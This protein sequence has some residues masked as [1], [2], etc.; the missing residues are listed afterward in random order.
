MFSDCAIILCTKNGEKFLQEQLDSLEAQTHGFDLYIND[1]GSND[2]TYKI[3]K[4]FQKR[5]KY[6][7]H[8]TRNIYNSAPMNFLKTLK[9]IERRYDLY[10]F[11]D[12]DDIWEK[13]KIEISK[14]ELASLD[15]KIPSLF[16]TSTLIINQMSDV[17]DSSKIFK[18]EPCFSNALVQSIAGG[19]T[20][21]FNHQT[22]D[23][24][25]KIINLD[26][27]VSHDWMAYIIVSALGGKVIYSSDSLVKYRK[28]KK[29]L[30][31][32]NKSIK[33]MFS[34]IYKLFQGQ[35]R[36]WT[37]KNLLIL[38]EFKL[39]NKSQEILNQFENKAHNGNFFER[40]N[41]IVNSNVFRQTYL[42]NVALHF[43]IFL[44]KI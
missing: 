41:F 42:S 39:P 27:V 29:N 10:F 18:K 32:P 21:C 16:C 14:M 37:K 43:A 22:R 1:D 19:N 31:G 36:E 9:K 23:L 25:D 33:E 5:S 12:Q 7:I 44:K 40:V 17:I 20:M 28:H 30:I 34:R 4:N 38:N 13:N 3:I 35:M 11:C 26:S 8:Y 6:Q 15:Q 24:L 2:Q